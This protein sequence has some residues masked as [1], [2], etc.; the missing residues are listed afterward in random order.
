MVLRDN[1][2]EKH[3]QR[4]D[5][6]FT[7]KFYPGGME[8]VLGICQAQFTGRLSNLH[9]ILPTAI[10]QEIKQPISFYERVEIMQGYL[11]SRYK[12]KND[13]HYLTFV[14]DCIAKYDNNSME[15]NTGDIAE[16]MFVTSKTINRYFN[17][18]VGISPKSYFNI[19]RARAAINAY[20]NEQQ[21]FL[22][23]NYGY[24][25]MSHFYKDVVKLT[26]RKL[27]AHT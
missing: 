14:R 4:G 22:P 17:K 11:L 10:I 16:K 2:I 23:Y 24:Y 21:L 13:D 3:K 9:A 27:T 1:T 5:C 18:V 19:I 15:L 12:N 20:V 26:G 7:V 8:A 6:I 25:D